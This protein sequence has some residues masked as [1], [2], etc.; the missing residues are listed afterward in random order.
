VSYALRRLATL[1]PLLLGITIIGYILVNATPGDPVL[2]LMDPQQMDLSPEAVAARRVSLGLDQ[3]M[4]VRYVIWL[5]EAATGNLG[6]SFRTHLPVT[7]TLGEKMSATAQLLV[8]AL[9]IAFVIA[10]PLGVLA[11][12]RQGTWVDYLS[13]VLALFSVSIPTFFLALGM[14]YVFSLKLK[15]LP[16]AG[17]FTF[18]GGGPLD[19]LAHL[20][21]PAVVLGLFISADL[22]R[23]TRASVLDV[24]A[25]D[26]LR[27]ARAKGLTEG[28]TLMRHALR[29]ALLPVVTIVGIRIP[30]FL[31]GA[32]VIEVVFQWPG[33]GQWSLQ[34]IQNRDY[35][36]LM[37]VTLVSA[38]IVVLINLATDIAY[39][40]I[41]PRI[42][43]G[44]VRG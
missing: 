2:M 31:A 28:A 36:V 23:Y 19:Y 44:G 42:R 20:V 1:P 7:N 33:M 12:V 35:P 6:Y 8:A 11:A 25:N 15:V 38:L 17:M 29:N 16:T 30:Q 43:L 21:M 18:G 14:I 4:P 41:D 37:A 3:P 27:T 13:N 40:W 26:Y 39:S 32:V 34:A 9:I 10:I 5:R 24:L 22:M